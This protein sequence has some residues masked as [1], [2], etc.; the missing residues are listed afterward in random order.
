MAIPCPACGKPN[1]LDGG[2]DCARC[3]CDLSML[4]AI[5]ASA[6][7]HL[8]RAKE[9]LRQR[10]WSAALA[11]AERSWEL[12]HTPHSARV[13]CLAA[14][15]MGDPAGLARW[16]FWSD[17]GKSFHPSRMSATAPSKRS[18]TGDFGPNK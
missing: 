13:A 6:V 10:D 8:G 9:Q 12:L 11:H 17:H 4:R 1:E 16:R 3:G 14:A 18:L 7:A 15:A 5:V 2:H